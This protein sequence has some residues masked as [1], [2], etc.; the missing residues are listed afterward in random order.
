MQNREKLTTVIEAILN[1]KRPHL[2]KCIYLFGS[3]L[4]KDISHLSD[5]DILI[6]YS[7]KNKG[8]YLKLIQFIGLLKNTIKKKTGTLT[9]VFFVNQNSIKYL[10]YF[11]PV[12]LNKSTKNVYGIDSDFL[13]D[14]K[15]IKRILNKK[16]I[17]RSLMFLCLNDFFMFIPN[18][19]TSQRRNN[20]KKILWYF[21][22]AKELK[23]S[24]KVIEAINIINKRLKIIDQE[25]VF[26]TVLNDIELLKL[27]TF[28][29]KDTKVYN[30]DIKIFSSVEFINHYFIETKRFLADILS[31]KVNNYSIRTY[32]KKELS[33][34]IKV[35]VL[36]NLDNILKMNGQKHEMY[37]K[38]SQNLTD[39][40]VNSEEY[41]KLKKCKIN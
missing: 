22:L 34:I 6:S 1:L 11:L 32:F 21:K 9:D 8:D 38:I 28:V 14:D 36:N 27:V 19:D 16:D 24:K 40:Y 7:P 26:D 17:V 25:N 23:S 13:K 18:I 12:Y 29:M 35:A 37:R 4:N 33:L 15:S 41:K 39:K 31:C 2:I 30:F 10:K 3:V 5:I 20:L